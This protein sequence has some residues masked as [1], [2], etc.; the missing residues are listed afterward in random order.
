MTANEMTFRIGGEAGQCVES[1]GAGFATALARGGLHVFG[2]QDY[3]SRIRWGLNFFQVRVHEQPLYSHED[4]V[5]VLLPLNEEALEAYHQALEAMTS[6]SDY[7]NYRRPHT[8]LKY[9]CPADYYRGDPQARLAKREEKLVQA[10]EA[11]KAH[12]MG[13]CGC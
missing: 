10:V 6:W 12:W 11:R 2:V 5:H 13:V 9:L 7:Y 4:A 3:M 8:A 1:G